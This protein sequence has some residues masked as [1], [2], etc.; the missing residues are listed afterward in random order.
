MN[1]SEHIERVSHHISGIPAGIEI[2]IWLVGVCALWL[3][4]GA[5]IV[6]NK[7]TGYRSWPIYR[8]VCWVCGVISALIAVIGPLA[9]R[10]HEDFTAHMLVH[11]LLGM[12]APLLMALSSPVTLLLRTLS[13]HSARRVSMLLR[14][15]LSR[16]F[17]HPIVTSVLNIGGLW[18]L[19]TTDL[20]MRM[21]ENLVLHL[22]V[23]FHVFIAGYLYT[24]SMIYMDPVSHRLPY[25][26][27]AIVMVLSLAGHGILSKYIYALPPA[28]VPLEQ[29]E[30][31]GMLMFYGG[32]A[33]DAAIIF[34]LC[35]QWYRATRPRIVVPS[36][37]Q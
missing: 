20:Y 34:I 13:V 19:Y 5:V 25:R 29:A 27:R 8:S 14:S 1:L 31:G 16:V 15:W 28:G 6:S 23:H 10:A 9:H 35:F 22:I 3:Y 21:H 12:L 4:I 30:L 7:R 11:L 24:V 37:G 36:I 33:I 26:Y 32:D 17:T 2:G 18:L